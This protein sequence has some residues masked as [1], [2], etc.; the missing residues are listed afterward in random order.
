M[1]HHT[2]Q[3]TPADAL[4][5]LVQ[6]TGK[7]RLTGAQAHAMARRKGKAFSPYRCPHC[8]GHHVGH[9]ETKPFR[10]RKH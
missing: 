7:D 9:H 8:G 2:P 6:C 4:A 3:I 5:A 10:R 1:G